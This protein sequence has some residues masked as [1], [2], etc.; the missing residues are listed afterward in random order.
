MIPAAWP[1][2]SPFASARPGPDT[3]IAHTAATNRTNDLRAV[4]SADSR[5]RIEFKATEGGGST[6]TTILIGQGKIRSNADQNTSVILDPTAGTTT[7]LDHSRKTFTRIGRAELKQLVDM[8]A[9]LEQAMASIPPEMRERM[10][11]R[12][13]GPQAVTS[14]TN[15]RATVAG[16]SCV[17]YRSMLKEQMTAEYCMADA[18][19]ID[20]PAADRATMIAA[21]AWSKE[22]AD[23]L[24]KGP[25]GRFADSSPF[26]DGQIPL[27]QTTMSG[28]TRRTSEFVSA[29]AAALDAGTFT[30]PPDYKEQKIDMSGRGRG[31]R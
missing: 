10:A 20:L 25:M 23:A 19:V 22:L 7:I 31:G 14:A 1:A 27:R 28:Q 13:G 16:K 29:G 6:L 30:V 24:A 18:S 26:R 11:G 8:M 17:I 2:A 15:E 9:Q 5:S 12:M 21:M 4:V 3:P